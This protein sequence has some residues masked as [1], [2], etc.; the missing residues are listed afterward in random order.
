MLSR[1]LMQ[2]ITPAS[3]FADTNRRDEARR[4]GTRRG[5]ADGRTK[6]LLRHSSIVLLHLALLHSSDMN[7]VTRDDIEE[8]DQLFYD[9]KSSAKLLAQHADKSRR[10][11]VPYGVSTSEEGVV[12]LSM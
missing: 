5:H 12:E 3:V 8:I 4:L 1:V 7:E 2:L 10:P 6:P 9:A 11:P